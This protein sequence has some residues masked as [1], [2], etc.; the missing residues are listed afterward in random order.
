M[1]VLESTKQLRISSTTLKEELNVLDFILWLN[2]YYVV[3]LDY[4]PL[5]LTYLVK[6]AEGLRG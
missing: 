4:F 6:F 1:E 3:F 5:F 2:F